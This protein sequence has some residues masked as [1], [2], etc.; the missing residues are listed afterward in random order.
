M[1]RYPHLGSIPNLVSIIAFRIK[2]LS[3]HQTLI[4]PL[5]TLYKNSIRKRSTFKAIY[6]FFY[7]FYLYLD[8]F[9]L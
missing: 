8:Q 3:S 2:N 1:F 6:L 4:Y 5:F 9:M 7:G